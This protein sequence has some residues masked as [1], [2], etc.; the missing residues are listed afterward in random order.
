MR[1]AFASRHRR[2]AV[3]ATSWR[4]LELEER[5]CGREAREHRG[6]VKREHISDGIPPQEPALT[7]SFR[8]ARGHRREVDGRLWIPD[9]ERRAASVSR[10]SGEIAD[11]SL[12][13][14]RISE[15]AAVATGSAPAGRRNCEWLAQIIGV[16]CPRG[17]CSH[18]SAGSR[19]DSSRDCTRAG[20]RRGP[21]LGRP[22]AHLARTVALAGLAQS[23]QG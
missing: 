17:N 23:C 3:E 1:P 9:F 18:Y 20:A 2:I 14:L 11:E 6:R 7:D 21:V 12:A 16:L 15:G 22:L 10:R 19:R 4:R 5:S 8:Q 13:F